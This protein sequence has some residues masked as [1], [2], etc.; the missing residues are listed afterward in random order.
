M[1]KSLD[2]WASLLGFRFWF[3]PFLGGWPGASCITSLCLSFLFCEIW[4]I[5]I[6]SPSPNSTPFYSFWQ[7]SLEHILFLGSPS[8]TMVIP[9]CDF[10]FLLQSLHCAEESDTQK[11]GFIMIWCRSY[12]IWSGLYRDTGEGWFARSVQGNFLWDMIPE[13]WLV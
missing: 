7:N 4:M 5:T 3:W 12:G 8:S 11:D 13:Q 6:S 1:V 9:K 2:S 10:F